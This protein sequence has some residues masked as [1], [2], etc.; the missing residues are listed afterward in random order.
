VDN[1]TPAVTLS[2]HVY[3]RHLNY[4]DRSEFVPDARV[5]RPV[6]RKVR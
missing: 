4:T 6:V 2:L 3:G 1:Q 5:E